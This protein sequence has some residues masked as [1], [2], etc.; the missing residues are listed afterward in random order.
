MTQDKFSQ[1]LD[2]FYSLYPE[3]H[4]QQCYFFLDE[5]QNVSGWQ[6]VVRRYLDSKK[7]KI[8]LTGSSAKLLSKEIAS[9]LR[10]RS[11][12]MEVWPFSFTEFLAAQRLILPK[13]PWG[14]KGMDQLKAWLK[15]Y[16]LQG[17]FPEV[18][19]L[20]EDRPLAEEDR[21]RILQDYT[22]V[23]IFR[24]IVER[25]Q[26]TNITLI[27]YLI[28]TL[29]KNV[30]NAFS[31]NKFYNNL[32]SQSLSVGKMTLHDYLSYIEDA[33][34]AFTVPLFSESLRKVQTNPRKIYAVDTGLVNANTLGFSENIGHSFENLVYLDLRR[35]GHTV[36]YYLTNSQPRLE[37]D[38]L[39]KD[40]LGKIHLFQVCWNIDDEKTLERETTALKEAGSELN[41]EGM[42]VTPESYFTDFLPS[43][44]RFR[45]I[46]AYA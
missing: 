46:R 33:Y 2:S 28:K 40:R 39:T 6:T 19:C 4:N 15:D 17:G 11:I 22:S 20:T 10:G 36:Y 21:R 32:K 38:F 12:A 18:S 1:L 43:L 34:L 25:H 26:I 3:N 29:L 41:L 5:I 8:Y 31:V 23:V 16:L 42:L 45:N 7:V 35:A 27:R 9:S 44:G 30:G 37:V 14:R 24:D 13:K